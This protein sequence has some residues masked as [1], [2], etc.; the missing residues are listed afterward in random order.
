MRIPALDHFDQSYPV[1]VTWVAK[2][3][4]FLEAALKRGALGSRNRH[5]WIRA[6]IL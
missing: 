4:K 2:R 5:Q 3:S 6:T 1:N